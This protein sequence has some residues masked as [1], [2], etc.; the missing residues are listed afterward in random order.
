MCARQASFSKLFLCLCRARYGSAYTSAARWRVCGRERTRLRESW[1][2]CSAAPARSNFS[3]LAHAAHARRTRPLPLP[4]LPEPQRDAL[5]L[6]FDQSLQ[7]GGGGELA[8]R[9]PP[10]TE[11]LA[12]APP[13]R[14]ASRARPATRPAWR[15]V[16]GPLCP[17]PSCSESGPAQLERHREVPPGSHTRQLR[18]DGTH[19]AIP[20]RRC[21]PGASRPSHTGVTSSSVVGAS[22]G[23]SANAYRPL[24]PLPPVSSMITSK[25]R[26]SRSVSQVRTVRRGGCG[27]R[28]SE[29]SA[30]VAHAT[31]CGAELVGR[32]SG[33]GLA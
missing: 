7:G 25:A 6:P 8:L 24:P 16:R 21:K 28:C 30:A 20:L 32:A 15:A 22:G 11:D 19:S 27:G 23:L 31:R 33:A 3:W 29:H 14:Y 5:R 4:S 2:A 1:E 17:L 12:P 13:L 18:L 26:P 9:P 10:A